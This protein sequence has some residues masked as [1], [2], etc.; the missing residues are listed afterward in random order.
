MEALL[1]YP[2]PGNIRELDDVIEHAFVVGEDTILD[3]SD[4]APELRGELP[5]TEP[6]LRQLERERILTALAKHHGRKAA[7]AA[8]LGISRSTLWRKLY[9]HQLR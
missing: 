4:L 1:R 6:S 5:P 9:E 3:L 7:A 8:E 2:W